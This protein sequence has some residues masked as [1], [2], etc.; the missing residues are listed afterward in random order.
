VPKGT[1]S[2][3][4][5][6]DEILRISDQLE[7]QF[8]REFLALVAQLSSSKQLRKL[9][10]DI[11]SGRLAFGDPVDVVLNRVTIDTSRLDE[12]SRKA[13]GSAARL[14]GRVVS[15]IQPQFNVTNPTVVSLARQ[16]SI[17]L[18]T[19]ISAGAK[20]SIRKIITEALEGNIT[21][22]EAA[23]KI[24]RHVGLLPSHAEAVDRYL[25]KMLADGVKKS[26]AQKRADEYAKRLLNSRANTIARTEIANAI[27]RGQVQMW[28]QMR[29]DG[30]IPPSTKMVWVTASDE[31]V[32]DI[33]GPMNGA[34]ADIYGTWDFGAG[35]VEYPQAAHPNCRCTSVLDI[36]AP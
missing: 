20:D 31:K 25:N 15:G 27:G 3:A 17:Q 35:P 21:S 16:M 29:D 32:C 28:R 7:G 23:R 8:R 36:G 30:Y 18:S 14:S 22:A 24:R 12:I 34:E 19:N 26:V 9:L 1:L 2:G 11:A 10:D 4:Q 6:A 5:L 13:L 33:C